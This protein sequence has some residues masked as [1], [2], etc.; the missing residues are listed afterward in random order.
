MKLKKKST[1]KITKKSTKEAEVIET[2]IEEVEEIEEIEVS[3]VRTPTKLE[4]ERGFISK[5]LETGD[6]SSVNDRQ[7][8]PYYFS[9]MN[10]KVFRYLQE[11][12]MKN[13]ELPT[14][15]VLAS[16]FPDFTFESYV[17]TLGNEVVGTEEPLNYWCEE[18]R[19]KVTHNTLCDSFEEVYEMLEGLNTQG[20]LDKIKQTILH[21]E[22]N[23]VETSAI[24]MTQDA[25]NRKEMYRKRKENQGMI[26]I[27]MGIDKLDMILKGMQEKQLITLIAKT[28]LGKTWFYVLLASHCMLNN[29]RVLFFTTEMSEE[30]VE[31]RIEA[32]LMGMMYGDFNYNKFKSGTLDAE[33]EKRYFEFLDRKEKLEPLIIETATGVSNVNAKIQQYKPD[34]VFIDGVYLMEDDRGAEQDWLRVAHIT[35]DLKMLAKNNKLPILINSQADRTTSTKTGPELDNIGFS[36]A[37]GHDSDVVLALFRDEEMLED[38]EMKV[39]V[40]K[41]REGTTGSVLLNWDFSTMNF[42]SIYSDVSQEQA[43]EGKNNNFVQIA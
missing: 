3:T 8:K 31:D 10:V 18:L 33:D 25:E 7:I 15:R 43:N 24:D 42:S 4:V 27:P 9:G 40:L 39:K 11:Y 21:I 34:V 6:M 16:Q 17:N 1:G 5:L 32:M 38:R 37:I 29:Y 41:Q 36:S 13:N 20:A 26:G 30:Q 35:R 14:S 19:K 2:D 22:S 12:F 23:L 28:G